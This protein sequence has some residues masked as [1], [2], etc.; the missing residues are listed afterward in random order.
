VRKSRQSELAPAVYANLQSTPVAIL[1]ALLGMWSIDLGTVGQI[2]LRPR[3][4]TA[5]LPARRFEG[6]LTP[7]I[8]PSNTWIVEVLGTKVDLEYGCASMVVEFRDD[9]REMIM[10]QPMP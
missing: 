10:T 8:P 9:T 6:K 4:V 3:F 5:Q 1:G 2:V 7:V